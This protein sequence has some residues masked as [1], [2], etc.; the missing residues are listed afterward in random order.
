M[1]NNN[2][3]NNTFLILFS[4][5]TAAISGRLSSLGPYYHT[6]NTAEDTSLSPFSISIWAPIL[7]QC[8]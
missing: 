5:I 1:C 2:N 3:T 4:F 6:T 7:E 8:S